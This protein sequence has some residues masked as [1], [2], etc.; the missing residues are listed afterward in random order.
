MVV[1]MFVLRWIAI[2]LI[3]IAALPA[4][5][6]PDELPE[7]ITVPEGWDS[8]IV[9][10]H[11]NEIVSLIAPGDPETA[12]QLIYY[13]FP[14]PILTSDLSKTAENVIGGLGLTMLNSNPPRGIP[15]VFYRDLNV[16]DS[17]ER[18]MRL[19]VIGHEMGANQ[20]IYVLTAMRDRFAALGGA[21]FMLAHLSEFDTLD[22]LQTEAKLR[23]QIAGGQGQAAGGPLP[24]GEDMIPLMPPEFALILRQVERMTGYRMSAAET[25]AFRD[26]MIRAAQAAGGTPPSQESRAELTPDPVSLGMNRETAPLQP[27]ATNHWSAIWT[28]SGQDRRTVEDR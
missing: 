22:M 16:E 9:N 11:N 4:H 15:G 21:N 3:G 12:S 10:V 19:L 25:R 5:A 18:V 2:A 8:A 7:H 13:R 28:A 6:L 14:I 1:S 20:H 17:D 26:S 24:G 27:A 23:D